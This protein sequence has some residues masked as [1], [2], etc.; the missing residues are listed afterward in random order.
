[1]RRVSG[2]G[3]GKWIRISTESTWL[4]LGNP[5]TSTIVVQVDV[6]WLRV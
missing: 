4:R 3:W 5:G 2:T 6:G 1:M